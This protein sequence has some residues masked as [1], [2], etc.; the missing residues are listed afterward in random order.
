MTIDAKTPNSEC[1]LGFREDLRLLKDPPALVASDHLSG[2][3]GG[4]GFQA[5]ELV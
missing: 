2:P 1:F 4:T 3:N 5:R